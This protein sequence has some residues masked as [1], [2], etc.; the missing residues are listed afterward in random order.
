MITYESEPVQNAKENRKSGSD[1]CLPHCNNTAEV[2][3]IWGLQHTVLATAFLCRN[4]PMLRVKFS[5]KNLIS[6]Q[7]G[8][9]TK[10]PS[11]IKIPANRD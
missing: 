3:L 5:N 7:H 9:I 10:F 11:K 2:P 4:N 6:P 1:I 8:K